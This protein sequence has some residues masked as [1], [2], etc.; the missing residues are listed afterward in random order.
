MLV[1]RLGFNLSAK[2]GRSSSR[3]PT[4]NYLPS[5]RNAKSIRTYSSDREDQEAFPE[6]KYKLVPRSQLPEFVYDPIRTIEKLHT[7]MRRSSLADEEMLQFA[8]SVLK[9]EK[10]LKEAYQE[11]QELPEARDV[12]LGA[13]RDSLAQVLEAD[14]VRMA[15][16]RERYGEPT[17]EDKETQTIVISDPMK[18]IEEFRAKPDTYSEGAREVMETVGDVLEDLKNPTYR[19]TELEEYTGEDYPYV[20]KGDFGTKD[21]PVIVPSFY[22]T[23]IVGCSGDY[24]HNTHPMHWH[25]V[26]ESRPTVCLHC[27][28]FFQL[29]KLD[30]N[31]LKDEVAGKGDY[32]V[33]YLL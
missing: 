14:K 20:L 22:P 6:G 4:R 23:R 13:F 12:S 24:P 16:L 33:E 9:D 2:T 28:Q 32:E 29:K 11:F 21:K 27:G 10:L 7:F 19:M 17:A 26:N 30:E 3:T 5:I 8:E 31:L 18:S 25:L 15:Q 1:S